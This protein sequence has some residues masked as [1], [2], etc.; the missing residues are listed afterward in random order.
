MIASAI[1]WMPLTRAVPLRGG[2]LIM[3]KSKSKRPAIS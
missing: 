2:P 3:Y 1:P